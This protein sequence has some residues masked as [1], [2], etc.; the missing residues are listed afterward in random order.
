M[1]YGI[2]R[3]STLAALAGGAT[4]PLLQDSP[5]E[6]I[7]PDSAPFIQTRNALENL[8]GPGSSVLDTGA[9]GDGHTDDTKAIQEIL[10]YF[11][12]V[13]GEWNFPPGVFKTTA[14]LVWNC[15]KTQR[16]HGRGKRAVYPGRYN[17]AQ[18]SQLA[19][20]LPMHGGRAAIQF[21]G[22][23][24]G[25]G[26]I[27]LRDIALA[28]LEIGPSPIAALGWD[29]ADHFLRDF[30]FINCS[31]HGFT[32]AFDL[33]KTGG[34]NTQM[35]M[36]K[37]QRCT[38]N[39]N[40][41]IARTLDG[42]QWNGFAFR[43]NEAGQN[44]Y[45][46]GDGGISIVAHNAM[47]AGNCLEGQRDP[48]RLAGSMR[49]VS[50][51]DNYFEVNVGSAAIHLQNIRGPFDIG[52]NSF[53]DCDPA[54]LN[55][56]T[57]LSNCGH[58]R[59]LGPY[60]SDGV[61]KMA[62]PVLGNGAA[63][64][65]V[66][67]P[68]TD[69]KTY[70]ML[71]MDGFDNGNVYTRAP[72]CSAL[73][74][75]RVTVAGRDIAPWNGQPMPVAYHTATDSAGLPIDV[76]I[77]GAAGSWAVM[78]WLFNRE[79]GIAK[80]SDPYVS[81]SVN[82]NGAPG[83]RDYVAHGFDEYWRPGE[84]CLLTA[85]IKLGTAM[86]RLSINLYPFGIKPTQG[87]RTRYLNPVVYVTDTPATIIPYVDDYTARSVLTPPKSEGF[88]PGDIVMNGAVAAAGQAHYVKLAGS[89]DRWAYA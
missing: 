24:D 76:A 84:W 62:L 3:R 22:S 83:S 86:T 68:R 52:A 35:G 80:P 37:A 57:L 67:N 44:G 55:H 2:T 39:R 61:N 14:P 12:R 32:S 65:N 79:P 49:G 75:Q 20:I 41:W 63:G 77:S 78:S 38:I 48:I 7:K 51:F 28:T 21:I 36:F 60:W 23:R 29:S 71:R 34:S 27:E 6:W 73:A 54:Q 85:A 1:T 15:T 16:V 30:A 17:P 5:R 43:D 89:A 88:Q 53:I 8:R 50:I 72:R 74:K 11:A 18:P 82:G 66:L 40:R 13:G 9:L 47:I 25:D 87:G 59:V 45:L 19:V 31:I 70:G 42:T 33:F 64:D 46:P 56:L 4:T 26:S 58:G 10:D 81:L 69:S